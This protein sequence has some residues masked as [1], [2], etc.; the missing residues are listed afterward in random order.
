MSYLDLG[1]IH[2]SRSRSPR[3]APGKQLLKLGLILALI[4]FLSWG[5]RQLFFAG[6]TVMASFWNSS[7]AVIAQLMPNRPQI[8]E[9][10]GVTNILLIGIDRR[11]EIPYSYQGPN[12]KMVK[13]GF[14]ADTIIIA[15][16]NRNTNQ[17]SLLSLPRDLWVQIP[18]YRGL[19]SQYAKINAAHA[20]GDRLSEGGSGIEL[21][22]KVV[23]DIL[24]I[25]IHYY[26]RIDFAGFVKGIDAL[27]GVDIEVERTFDDYMYPRAGYEE[28]PWN[29]RWEHVRF[30]AGLQHMDGERALK[31][32]RSRHALGIEGTDF[33]RAKRQ[34]KVI[35][36]VK[37][38][39]LSSQTLLNPLKIK[40]LYELVA[41]YLA[42]D[43]QLNE[44]PLF[45]SW[46]KK[47]KD[48]EV[49]TYSLTD[50]GLNLLT[51]PSNLAPYGYAW[52][53]IPRAGRDNFTE[54]QK[55]VHQILY[56]PPATPTPLPA[57]EENF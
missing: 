12:G 56:S 1:T 48:L 57:A 10:Q 32:A 41:D 20:L 7:G 44:I 33:A 11:N 15:S 19:P 31:Y 4:L 54:I 26:A 50:E 45:L 18:A 5:L 3:W 24:Q 27:G 42:T 38:K 17:I 39:V 21:L 8:K 23:E 46:A 36:A 53:V 51:T 55:Y 28:A 9:D 16:Y 37:N 40:Q 34:Q 13:N 2:Q 52:V 49:K 6:S 29:Q 22:T 47:M 35:I 25:P 30:E 43:I 14:L